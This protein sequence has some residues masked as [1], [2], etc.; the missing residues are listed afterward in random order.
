MLF[1]IKMIN[2]ELN[3]NLIFFVIFSFSPI[4]EKKMIYTGYK[5]IK[6]IRIKDKKIVLSP[7]NFFRPLARF[8]NDGQN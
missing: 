8:F 5:D 4:I 6:L 7:F 3:I 1:L 2:L